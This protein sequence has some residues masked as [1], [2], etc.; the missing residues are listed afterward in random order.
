MSSRIYIDGI[1]TYEAYSLS[2][3]DGSYA[4]LVSFPSLKNVEFN[5]WHEKN[6]VDPDL[7]DPVLDA[8]NITL[9]FFIVGPIS[10]YKAFIGA[11]S[12]GSYHNI[13]FAEIGLILRLRLVSCGS[14]T[15]VG[16]LHSFELSFS[17]DFPQKGY[18]YEM[19]MSELTP[20][21]DFAIDDKDIALYGIR[22]KQGTL[23]GI[24]SMPDVKPNLTVDIQSVAG[25]EYDGKTV[26]YKSKEAEIICLMKSKSI[27]E[28]WRNWNALL[29][30]LI[31]PGE[32]ELTISSINAKVPFYYKG[33][34]V[35][36]FFC[37][38]GNVWFEFTISIELFKGLIEYDN[39][40]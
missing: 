32:R 1:D 22:A 16:N 26:V 36:S 21:N 40:Q 25:I 35:E 29:Y 8:R 20:L 14:V 33:C 19:P 17:D 2:L 9:N 6:G 11:I 15:S 24:L 18:S 34:S 30:D 38:D 12:D 37:D 23:D 39:L 13:N 10:L 7:S 3:A 27:E 31:R 28:F 5:D 4:E